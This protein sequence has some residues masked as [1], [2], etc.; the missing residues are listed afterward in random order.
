MPRMIVSANYRDRKSDL[1]WLIREEGQH[2][3][4]AKEVS[5]ITATGVKFEHSSHQERGFGCTVV[6]VCETAVLTPASTMDVSGQRIHFNGWDGFYEKE[7][8]ARVYGCGRLTLNSDGSMYKDAVATAD[9]DSR[10][11]VPA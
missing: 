4:Q 10:V 9:A 11:A 7:T 1:K 3:D 5:S 8:E 2:P 6:A